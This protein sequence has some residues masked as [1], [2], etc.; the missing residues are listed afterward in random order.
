[1]DDKVLQWA[2]LPE[3]R[4]DLYVDPLNP[5]KC[6]VNGAFYM[7]VKAG[8]TKGKLL[9]YVPKSWENN[10]Q[11]LV[12][13]PPKAENV[14]TF[15]CSSGLC[16]FAL[17]KRVMT[18]LLVR[19]NGKTPDQEASLVNAAYKKLQARDYFVAMQDC[20]YAMGFEDGCAPVMKA[21]MA[22]SS[23][24]SGAAFLGGIQDV[25]EENSS[26]EEDCGT[27]TEEMYI[28]GKK[29]QLPVWLADKE[30]TKDVIQVRDYWIRQNQAEQEA[31][32]DKEGTAVYLPKHLS[33]RWSVNEAPIAQVRVTC[34]YTRDQLDQKLLE[35][36][37]SYIGAARRH[38]C[39]RNKVLRYYRDP[40]CRENGAGYH[41]MVIDGLKR[42]WYEYVPE[43]LK[44]EEKPIPLVVVF[45][46]RGGNAQTFF[47][48]TDMSLEAEERGFA[49]VF[50]TSDLCQIKENGYGG[51][52]RWNGS[53]Q[54]KEIDS[55]P[56]IRAMIEDVSSRIRI[57]R[58]RIYACGQSSGG[59]MTMCCAFQAPD[60]FAAVAPWSGYAYPD[61]RLM[62]LP[63]G[64]NGELEQVPV[65][66]LC[67]KK[68]E[69]F[70]GDSFDLEH[71]QSELERFICY[72]LKTW[73][74][75]SEG[76]DSYSCYPIDY[77]IWKRNGVPMFT[78]GLVDDM[79]HANYA[80]ESRI[81]YEDFMCRFSKDP[82][83]NR[84]YMQKKI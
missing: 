40:A 76:Y 74:M 58:S 10:D 27:Q 31:L 73:K 46:G 53:F 23:D 66:L 1:M 19:E 52:R 21:M 62:K 49:A 79:P 45:H 57:D 42:E 68:D 71:P 37:W 50:P 9:V 18:A 12:A 2:R 83:G 51:I 32:Y 22:M 77:F 11:V 70:G 28:S 54:G 7:D 15:L 30:E 63:S 26:R 38:R 3:N 48:I 72:V 43:R 36:I 8:E 84:Y 24:W 39:Y 78:L 55:M 69:S 56:F 25:T 82:L 6:P 29:G 33:K 13:V 4:A 20:F 59:Y 75:D 5:E 80:E 81:V 65:Y 17:K 61:A 64:F 16:G 47:D 34:G 35:C 60:L 44:K 41:S 14:E 67:G